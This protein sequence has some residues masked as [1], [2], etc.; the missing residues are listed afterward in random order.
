MKVGQIIKIDI[1]GHLVE[2]RL[3]AIRAF[4]TID[5]MRMSDKKCFRVSGLMTTGV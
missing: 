2:C 4:G 3:L 5:V 1:Y